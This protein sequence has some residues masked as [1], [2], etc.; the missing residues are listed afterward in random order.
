MHTL[1]AATLV[2]GLCGLA[3]G[4][5]LAMAS[6]LFAVTADPRISAI[7]KILPGANCSGCGNA[8]CYLY[9]QRIVEENAA[10]NLCV[11][12]SETGPEIGRAL[13]REVAARAKMIAAV[14]CAGGSRALQQFQYAGLSSCRLAATYSGGDRQCRYSCLGFGDCV[15]V[16]PFD[17]LSRDGRNAPRVDALKCTGCGQCA[18]ECPQGVILLVPAPSRPLVACSTR[19]PGKTVRAICPGGCISCSRCI[20]ACPVNAIAVRAG[21]VAIDYA[22]CTGCGTCIE[23]CPRSCILER[24]PAQAV[25]EAG[26]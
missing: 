2:L 4:I 8:S 3:V 18:E 16:C 15:A 1:V 14:A 19:D 26:P 17:A 9:A 21:R 22:C 25:Q 10:P 23:V 20:K 6:R 24:I 13:G 5:I 7:E 11:L 12:G